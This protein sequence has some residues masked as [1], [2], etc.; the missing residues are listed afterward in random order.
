MN[1]DTAQKVRTNTYRMHPQK[2]ARVWYICVRTLVPATNSY[3]QPSYIETLTRIYPVEE[4]VGEREAQY[5]GGNVLAGDIKLKL[6]GSITITEQTTLRC[7][8]KV[9]NIKKLDRFFN[10]GLV[11][12]YRIYVDRSFA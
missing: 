4:E 6:D 12:E 7:D 3:T 8:D 10:G 1:G 5:V 9:A 11:Q 2:S